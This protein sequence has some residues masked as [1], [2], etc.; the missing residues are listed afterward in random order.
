MLAGVAAIDM[1][2]LVVAADEGV[3]VLTADGQRFR[4]QVL[5]LSYYDAASDSGIAWNDL[6]VGIAWPE[7]GMDFSLSPKDLVLP[8]LKD[9]ARERMTFY[10]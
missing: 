10:R 3:D 5:G 8:R 1:A 6:D 4:S 2:L 9:L 7:L